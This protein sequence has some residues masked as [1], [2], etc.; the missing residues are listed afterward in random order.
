MTDPYPRASLQLTDW[1]KGRH[2]TALN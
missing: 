1:Q 2:G